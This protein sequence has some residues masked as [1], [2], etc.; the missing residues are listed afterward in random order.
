MRTESRIVVLQLR[1]ASGGA[2]GDREDEWGWSGD[3][4]S[5]R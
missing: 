5:Q 1:I 3:G 4:V 2:E